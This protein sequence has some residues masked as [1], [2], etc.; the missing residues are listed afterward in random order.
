MLFTG[1]RVKGEEALGMGLCDRLVSLGELREITSSF[2]REIA[3]SAPLAV[4]SIRKTL[5]GD[6]ADRV[7]AATLHE[8]A[9][10][11]R[12]SQTE[13]WKEGIKASAERRD[14]SFRRE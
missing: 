4:E 14:P 2:T 12:L 9:E 11:A 6:L 3:K 1:R 5:R 8:A 7:E 13:D 10:Q